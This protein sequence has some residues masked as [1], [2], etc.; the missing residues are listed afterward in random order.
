MAETSTAYTTSFPEL[1]NLRRP[2]YVE[3]SGWREEDVTP[4]SSEHQY[5]VGIGWQYKPEARYGAH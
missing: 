2:E 4:P 3:G 5:I 1:Q